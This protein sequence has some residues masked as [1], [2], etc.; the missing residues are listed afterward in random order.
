MKTTLAAYLPKGR[1]LSR[2]RQASVALLINRRGGRLTTRSASSHREET[3]SPRPFP[4]RGICTRRAMPR[5]RHRWKKARIGAIRSYSATN[6]W[7]HP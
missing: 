4:R 2:K 5:Q 3:A 1:R 7:N 6:A